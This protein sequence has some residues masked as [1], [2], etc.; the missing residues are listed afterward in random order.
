MAGLAMFPFGA[1]S[2][3]FIEETVVFNKYLGNPK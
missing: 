3:W 1:I 2:E